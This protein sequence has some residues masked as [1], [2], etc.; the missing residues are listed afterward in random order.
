MLFGKNKEKDYTEEIIG[1]R[2]LV[3]GAGKS[4][5]GSVHLLNRVGAYPVLLEQNPE[6]TVSAIREKL[7]YDDRETEI[8]T[9]ELPEEEFERIDAVVPSPGVPMEIPLLARFRERKVPVLSEVELAYRFMKGKLIAI[10][11]TNGKTTTTALTGEILKRYWPH[12]PEEVFVL[13]NI[14]ESFSRHALETTDKSVTVAE[15]SS[16]ALEAVEAFHA[17]ISAILNITPD[18]LDR[19]GTMEHYAEI[20]KRITCNQF[21][22]KKRT[23]QKDYCILNR[24]D[25][26]T[27]EFGKELL[28][29]PGVAAFWFSSTAR[30]EHEIGLYLD[31][32]NIML[33]MALS[34]KDDLFVMRFSESRLKGV[35]NAENVM[36]ALG[37]SALM[38]GTTPDKLADAVRVFQPVPHRIEYIATKSGVEYYNDSKATNPDSAIQGILAMDRPTILIGGGYDK[39]SNYD[40]WTATFS[41]RV[42]ELVLVGETADAIERSARKNAFT[43]IHRAASFDE[44]LV[45]CTTQ[46]GSGDAVLLS[47]ACASWGMFA[48]F[49]ERGDRFREYVLSL[50]D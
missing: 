46:A 43:E 44:A 38:L 28:D 20:K 14:G 16:F 35:C 9:G 33:S 4:G 26:V 18:H 19:H 47:P 25:P 34:P 45:Y 23:E 27:L 29:K 5:T 41:G 7:D 49:E 13:G 40:D 2:V 24:D 42:K 50:T 48:N 21:Q 11:G 22:K 39:Q 17:N 32:D 12:G 30:M 1:K 3:I 37:I 8:F 31:G 6:A 15:I 10:T 36:A